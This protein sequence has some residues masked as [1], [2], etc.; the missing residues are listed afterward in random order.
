MPFIVLK[1][2][3]IGWGGMITLAM[4][5][6]RKAK[7]IF[8]HRDQITAAIAKG[9]VITIDNGI[10]TL[11]TVASLEDEYNRKIYPYL[12]AHLKSCRPKD[13]PQHAESIMRVVNSDNQEQY[14]VVL[15]QRFDDLSSSQQKRVKKLLRTFQEI[16]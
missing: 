4:I 3:R 5:A 7:E 6:D 2:I 12:I 14:I 1:P 16:K 9:S 10:K 13:V 11:A 15:N 8:K